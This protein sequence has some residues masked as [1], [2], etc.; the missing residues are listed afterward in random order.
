MI[1]LMTKIIFIGLSNKID[2]EPLSS[3]TVSGALIDKIIN[4][5]EFSCIKTNLVNLAPINDTGKLRYPNE[6]EKDQGFSDLKLLLQN[7]SPYIAVCLGKNVAD[8]LQGKID[9]TNT[10]YIK[11]PVYIAVYRRKDS[12]LYVQ[13]TVDMINHM[14]LNK[15]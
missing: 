11:H 15:K 7:N 8:Y 1:N 9:N 10:L 12:D 4:N 6:V 5:L 14:I 13:N 2:T 3:Q